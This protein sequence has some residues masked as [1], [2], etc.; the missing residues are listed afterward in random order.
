MPE[1]K[2]N[3]EELM[4]A[5]ERATAKTRLL[6]EEAHNLHDSLEVAHERTQRLRARITQQRAKARKAREQRRGAKS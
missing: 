5:A 4:K 6:L 3:L 2:K 1:K